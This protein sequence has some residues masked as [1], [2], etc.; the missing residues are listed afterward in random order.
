MTVYLVPIG[1]G[2]LELYSE[3]PDEPRAADDDRGVT[4][5][6]LR[7]L[8]RRWDGVVMDARLDD[9]GRRSAVTR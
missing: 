2:R 9:G 7:G 1:R 5:R 4:R 3:A 8:G 6:W